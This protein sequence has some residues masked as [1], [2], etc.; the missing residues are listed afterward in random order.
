MATREE[1]MSPICESMIWQGLQALTL[2]QVCAR[3]LS[4]SQVAPLVAR[5]HSAWVRGHAACFAGLGMLGSKG[6][7]DLKMN[8]KSH[9]V[10]QLLNSYQGCWCTPRNDLELSWMD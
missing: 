1:T 5:V 4:A 6:L 2:L 3:L 7:Q 10:M 8:L 9:P